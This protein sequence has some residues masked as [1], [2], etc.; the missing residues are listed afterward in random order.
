MRALLDT[1]III[2]R[3]AERL[4]NEDIGFLFNWLDRLKIEKCIHP[5]TVDE[6]NKFGDEK[7]VKRMNVKIGNYNL[8]KTVAP[9]ADAVKNVVDKLD[10]TENDRIDTQL[11][12]EVYSGRVDL[13]ISEDKNIH[14]K[15][16]LLGISGKIF[17]I[18]EYL[19]KVSTEN[20]GL[21]D[22]K[23]LA[24]K[25]LYFGEVNLSDPFFDSFRGD[26][27][28]FD[29]WFV[30]KSDEI[31][32]IC[33]QDQVLS[34]FLYIKVEG[35]GENYNDIVPPFPNKKR[36]KIG[37]FK[38][39][40]NGYKIGERF[41][42][43]IFDNALINKVEEIYVTI[44]DKTSE[45]ERLISLLE[46]YGFSYYGEK[47]TGNGTEKVYTKPFFKGN[48]TN[49]DDPKIGYPFLATDTDIFLVPIYPDYH[50]ELFPDSILRTE[51]PKD[52]VENEP[53]R[54]AISK[55]YISR[56]HERDL[57]PGDRVVFYRT[58][59]YYEGVATT[60]GVV[61]SVIT[62]I[63]DVN[64]FI[65]LCRKRSVFSDEDLVKHW[66]YQ[67]RNRPFIVNFLYVGSFKRRPNLKWLID[68]EVVADV[69][70]VPRGF[71][72]ISQENFD[73]I[74]KYSRS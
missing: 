12:N 9:L 8:L 58:G 71:A 15:A 67:P 14:T 6:L 44:F 4:Q 68:N 3:E 64:T 36:L 54:N 65:Q 41:L 74:V 33:Y 45:H 59:G 46:D 34:A 69:N 49:K 42:K 40:A 28:E 19:E 62:D 51:S 66:N 55:V 17:K 18:D 37:T 43:I 20:P 61:E 22:Y 48:I 2:H 29:T 56:S 73:N 25:K 32:Y 21:I 39:T 70:S 1:N 57:K 52:F 24:V 26:Y 47:V 38:V 16:S 50:T 31:S 27:A 53:H 72:H 60:V 23:V 13:L 30:K 11:V 7:A 63:P 35:A 10:K 5:A